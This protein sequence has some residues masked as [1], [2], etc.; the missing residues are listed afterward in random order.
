MQ[1]V[2]LIPGLVG[3]ILSL[4]VWVASTITTNRGSPLG[5]YEGNARLFAVLCT[6]DALAIVLYVSAYSRKIQLQQHTVCDPCILLYI[7][8]CFSFFSDDVIFVICL[9]RLVAV[10]RPFSLAKLFSPKRQWAAVTACF[11]INA[12]LSVPDGIVTFQKCGVC[13]VSTSYEPDPGIQQENTT[14]IHNT[15]QAT[16]T[17]AYLGINLVQLLLL[18]TVNALLMQSLWTCRRARQDTT[19]STRRHSRAKWRSTHMILAVSIPII[20]KYVMIGI[21][22]VKLVIHNFNTEP[23]Q[24]LII[25][26]QFAFIFSVSVNVLFYSCFGD[27]FRIEMRRMR[28][29]MTRKLGC[30]AGSEEESN[31]ESEVENDIGS[32]YELRQPQRSG[33]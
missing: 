8:D 32:E 1:L 26:K 20:V 30:G 11:W 21:V 5:W 7:G 23:V 29:K 13:M 6:S 16:A 3:N 27:R 33:W 10:L 9:Q 12:L 2:I 28:R 18:L 14:E 19:T 4:T 24:E 25:C 31:H 22:K 17:Q 15:F